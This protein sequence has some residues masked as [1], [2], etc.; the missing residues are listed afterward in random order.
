MEGKA[1]RPRMKPP[2]MKQSGLFARPTCMNNVESLSIVPHLLRDSAKTY[3]KYG[4]GESLG[5]KLVSVGGN[6]KNLVYMKFHS[7]LQ[8]VKSSTI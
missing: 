4:V 5:T 1:G 8:S 2:F 3:M 7:V 6:V